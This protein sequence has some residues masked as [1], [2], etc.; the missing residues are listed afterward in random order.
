[1]FHKTVLPF[2]LAIGTKKR[3]IGNDTTNQ[4]NLL[5]FFGKTQKVSIEKGEKDSRKF[6]DNK[7]SLQAKRVCEDLE[8]IASNKK[9][10]IEKIHKEPDQSTRQ[11][12]STKVIDAK[13]EDQ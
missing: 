2:L 5:N 7:T 10:K 3:K 11:L 8:R 1:M 12:S 6:N 13:E 9:Q 4:Q